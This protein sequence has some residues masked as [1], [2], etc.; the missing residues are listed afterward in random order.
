MYF[1]E[2]VEEGGAYVVDSNEVLG[3]AGDNAFDCLLDRFRDLLSREL[4]CR[5]ES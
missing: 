4:G 5:D 3:V 1:H 2:T